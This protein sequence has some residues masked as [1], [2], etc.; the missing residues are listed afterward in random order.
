MKLHVFSSSSASVSKKTHNK[1][2]RH[3]S[4][5]RSETLPA[6]WRRKVYE[7][8]EYKGNAL[9]HAAPLSLYSKCTSL[10][11]FRLFI[12]FQATGY[13]SLQGTGTLPSSLETYMSLKIKKK[14]KKTKLNLRGKC[15]NN[16]FAF[17]AILVFLHQNSLS[18]H[19]SFHTC[20]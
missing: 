13:S 20:V 11:A 2:S 15:G 12:K 6:L 17:A 10:C 1:K 14:V 4:F 19:S 7:E 18:I 5:S 3:K 9:I 16:N 8:L